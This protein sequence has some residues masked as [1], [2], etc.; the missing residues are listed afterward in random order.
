MRYD[1]VRGCGGVLARL[2]TSEHSHVARRKLRVGPAARTRRPGRR[3]WQ[4]RHARAEETRAAVTFTGGHE[5]GR[6]DFGRP[7]PLIAAAL[8]VEPEVFREAFSGVTP[9]RGRGPTSSEARQNKA[10]L[11]KVLAPRA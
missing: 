11:M 9:C 2:Q 1:V 4:K 7:V 3:D 6:D 8:G 10:A 5:I